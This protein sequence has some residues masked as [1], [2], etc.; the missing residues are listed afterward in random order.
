MRLYLDDDSIARAL[1]S[2]LRQAGHDVEIPRDAGLKGRSDPVQLLHAIKSQRLVLTGNYDDFEE[3]HELVLG[4]QG[5]H[6]GILVVRKE[7][8]PKRDMAPGHIVKAIAKALAASIPMS[9][10]FV[11]LNHW[12]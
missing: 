10:S 2:G 5:S 8:N 3:L 9:G 12:R 7:N 11:V 6:P 4:A 1:V